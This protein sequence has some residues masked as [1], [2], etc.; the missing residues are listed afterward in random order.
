MTAPSRTTTLPPQKGPADEDRGEGHIDAPAWAGKVAEIK[1]GIAGAKTSASLKAIE[2]EY[3]KHAVSLPNDVA[4]E[5]EEL[6]R[7]RKRTLGGEG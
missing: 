5:I 6:L 3:V 4:S 1:A 2:A 7:N